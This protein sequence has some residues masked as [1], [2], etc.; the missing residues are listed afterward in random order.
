MNFFPQKRQKTANGMT[1]SREFESK[2]CTWP[3]T[4]TEE[5]VS[6][7]HFHV[8]IETKKIKNVLKLLDMGRK[9]R[10][11]NVCELQKNANCY[12]LK[13][14]HF[15]KKERDSRRGFFFQNFN[16]SVE[17]MQ[18]FLKRQETLWIQ[19]CDNY[20]CQSRIRALSELKDFSLERPSNFA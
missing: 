18:F 19:M 3:I 4:E 7:S 8:L 15:V 12:R 10:L 6:K 20:A 11:I 17:A 1:N 14:L 16:A 13:I 2:L 5:N 9:Y